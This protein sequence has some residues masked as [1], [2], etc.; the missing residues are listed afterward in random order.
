MSSLSFSLVSLM[1]FSSRGFHT[2]AVV[3]VVALYKLL[4][5]LRQLI[6]TSYILT[7]VLILLPFHGNLLIS[8]HMLLAISLPLSCSSVISHSCRSCSSIIT[9]NKSGW[10]CSIGQFF[11]I[12]SRQCSLWPCSYVQTKWSLEFVGFVE[13][14]STIDPTAATKYEGAKFPC[15][16]MDIMPFALHKKSSSLKC[17]SCMCGCTVVH[18][19]WLCAHH[20]SQQCTHCTRLNAYYSWLSSECT[21]SVTT[22][23]D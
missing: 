13:Q 11:K 16:L 10:M 17:A 4:E 8:V 21:V 23:P 22:T 9:H 2:S 15:F 7:L 14:L 19:A 1:G 5:E 18:H 3:C 20:T 6:H 12:T